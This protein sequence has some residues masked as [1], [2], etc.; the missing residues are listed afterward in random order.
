MLNESKILILQPPTQR[1]H[2]NLHY[3]YNSASILP[4]NTSRAAAVCH[5]TP[6]PHQ[7]YVKLLTTRHHNGHCRINFTTSHTRVGKSNFL[8]FTN[9]IPRLARLIVRSFRLVHP[10][11]LQYTSAQYLLPSVSYPLFQVLHQVKTSLILP[12]QGQAH[13]MGRFLYAMASAAQPEW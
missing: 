10:A 2:F 11:P 5:Q 13:F 3:L 6:C 8:T 7:K 1:Y 12:L 9:A 4:S